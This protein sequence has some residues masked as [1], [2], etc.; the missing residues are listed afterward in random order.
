MISNFND[1]DPYRTTNDPEL[2]AAAPPSGQP[3]CNAPPETLPPASP[4][5]TQ[6]SGMSAEEASRKAPCWP[7]VHGYHILGVLGRGGMGI[8]YHALQLALKRDV[9]LKTLL[10]GSQGGSEELARFR[11]EG[12]A[13]ARLE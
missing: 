1:D 2:P 10:A 4:N 5:T 11:T 7:K 6:G 9:V 3:G 12:E 8:V 13:A